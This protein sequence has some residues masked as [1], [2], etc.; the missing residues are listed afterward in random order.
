V[1]SPLKPILKNEK[2][3]EKANSLLSLTKRTQPKEKTNWKRIARKK[4]KQAQPTPIRA[5]VN[6]SGTKRPTRLVFFEKKEGNSPSQKRL[7]KTQHNTS[8]LIP[9]GSAV[10]ARQNRQEQ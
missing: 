10:S 2:L 8:N 1:T 9:D 5:Q 6:I 4:G 7:C 3:L